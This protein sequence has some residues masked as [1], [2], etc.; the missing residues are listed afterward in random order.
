[1]DT[2]Q[3]HWARNPGTYSRVTMVLDV[4]MPF[5]VPDN[6]WGPWRPDDPNVRRPPLGS[7]VR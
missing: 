3:T 6:A 1:M 5:V 7:P 4:R 2:R